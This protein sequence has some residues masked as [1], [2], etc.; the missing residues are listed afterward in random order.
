M[1]CLLHQVI[2]CP[3]RGEHSIENELIFRSNTR[4]IFHDSR[5]FEAGSDE[6]VKV[7]KKFLMDR[8]ATTKLEKRIHAIW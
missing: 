7:M 4:F 6:E 3:Q 2:Y 1:T 5:G 8:A